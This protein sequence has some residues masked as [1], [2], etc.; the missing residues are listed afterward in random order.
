MNPLKS[1]LLLL[2][3]VLAD[4]N[5]LGQFQVLS[6]QT[7]VSGFET[8]YSASKK[9]VTTSKS[10]IRFDRITDDSL[11]H[12]FTNLLTEKI[13]PY[14]LG[15]LWSFEGHTSVPGSGE[16]ACGYFVSTTL[17]DVGFNLNRYKFAQ[18]LPI[19]EAKTLSMGMPLLEINNNSTAERIDILKRSLKEG[20]YFIGFDHSHVGY[21]Q[22]KNG[23]L[24]V[25]HSNYISAK[26]VVIEKIEESQV[27]S[28]Y[29]RIY[30]AEISTNVPL[31]KKWLTN[32][33][34]K[35]ISE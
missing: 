22:K 8:S 26:G 21:I 33:V 17:Q 3:L 11:S 24:F 35:V 12:L 5:P 34:I 2:F 28:Y 27:F 25:I 23:E 18:L 7:Y 19:N 15:T 32:E 30:I 20:I 16:I 10:R 9:F 14:W 1:R 29:D 13:I 4:L 6:A 31:L